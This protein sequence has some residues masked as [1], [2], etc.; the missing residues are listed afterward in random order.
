MML[1]SFKSTYRLA[2]ALAFL[3]SLVLIATGLRIPVAKLTGSVKSDI[4][5]FSSIDA[6]FLNDISGRRVLISFEGDIVF[7]DGERLTTS[8]AFLSIDSMSAPGSGITNIQG[9]EVSPDSDVL[10]TIDEREG[11][12]TLRV[13]GPTLDVFVHPALGAALSA[14]IDDCELTLCEVGNI[15][16]EMRPIRILSRPDTPFQISVEIS[17]NAFQ[18]VNQVDV[19][20]LRFWDTERV[21]GYV[22]KRSGLKEGNLR[23][24][25]TPDTVQELQ[26]GEFLIVEPKLV[27]LRS[28]VQSDGSL[29]LQFSGAVK[30]IS[31]EIAGST[32]SRKPSVFDTLVRMKRLQ[33]FFGILSFLV[34]AGIGIPEKIK[35]E[36]DKLWHGS[37]S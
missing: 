14:Q 25:A 7:P 31:G 6:F 17:N 20:E 8:D 16:D 33:L 3:S 13:N 19:D 11:L 29:L 1:R 35:Q 32:Y 15:Y 9:F 26:R 4:V 23:F 22:Q 21:N 2:I 30:Q 34:G 24:R 5:Y 27:R 10:I 37:S 36:V 28:L 12:M 18:L